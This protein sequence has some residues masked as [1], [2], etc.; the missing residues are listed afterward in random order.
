MFF[1]RKSAPSQTKEDHRTALLDAIYNSQ[2]VAEFST[3]GVILYANSLY[4][5]LMGYREGELLNRQH[6]SL[7]DERDISGSEYRDFWNRLKN[8]E[9]M[10]GQ[11]RRKS[12]DG[13]L[14][15]LD[16]SY[17][18]VKD[19]SGRVEKIVKIAH[20]VSDLMADN[21][22]YSDINAAVER[23][24]AVIEFDATGNI[25]RANANFLGAT[26]YTE[27]EVIGKHH[28][29]FVTAENAESQDYRD[30][31]K[32]LGSGQF[33]SSRFH[34]VKKDGSD[35]WLEAS[36]S[37]LINADGDV[38]G[39]IKFATDITESVEKTNREIERATSAYHITTATEQTAEKGTE[40]IQEAAREMTLISEAVSETSSVISE[41]DKQSDA[42]T[43]IVNT[44]RGIADQTNLLALNA[45]IEA[46]RA[47]EQGRGFAVVADEVRQLAA[48]TSTSTE[49]ISAMIGKMQAGTVKAV[50][51]ME[52]CREQAGHGMALANKA[53]EVILEIRDGTR[54]AVSA[55]SI[56]A[57]A[58]R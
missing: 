34:R 10:N 1:S 55:V 48:R 49:E 30:F 15:W 45:A 29:M 41:L 19:A 52:A 4:H 46:A 36:Y 51:S 39:V 11:F 28:R 16:G 56:F 50:D 20:D 44:I 18:P 5:E 32:K 13:R 37:P 40:I 31:W 43:S 23:S 12:A 54:K 38:Y 53:G 57:D 27:A 47:G 58:L 33:I 25:K 9:R 42:I 3:D 8:G 35:L 17:A 26:G 2:A 24:M 6:S 21:H 22:K 14:L 7:C